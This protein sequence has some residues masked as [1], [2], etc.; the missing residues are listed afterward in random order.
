[1][2]HSYHPKIIMTCFHILA[3]SPLI[4]A[5][6]ATSLQSHAT[7]Q[8]RILLA[9]HA[10]ACSHSIAWQNDAQSSTARL[11]NNG[12]SLSILNMTSL[13]NKTD[14][15]ALVQKLNSKAGTGHWDMQW[16]CDGSPPDV[17]DSSGAC[18]FTID[19]LTTSNEN[20]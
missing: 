14:C 3:I 12:S 1:M 7:D 9:R 19:K 20:T 13:V 15:Q 8:F 4:A 18:G 10:N 2:D 16:D 17:L 11:C 5:T 6:V